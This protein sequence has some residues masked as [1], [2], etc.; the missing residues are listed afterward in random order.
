MPFTVKRNHNASISKAV[1]VSKSMFTSVTVQSSLEE[2]KA[3]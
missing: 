1:S 2:G 3:G